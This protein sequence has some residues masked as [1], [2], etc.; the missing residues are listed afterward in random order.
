MKEPKA[1][2]VKPVL[3]V[4][5]AEKHRHEPTSSRV[6]KRGTR[7]VADNCLASFSLRGVRTG[8]FQLPPTPSVNALPQPEAALTFKKSSARKR[9]SKLNLQTEYD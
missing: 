4:M 2:M 8:S 9:K 6:W 5:A 3:L 7:G 1:E